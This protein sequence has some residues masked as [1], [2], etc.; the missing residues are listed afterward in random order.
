MAAIILETTGTRISAIASLSIA[1]AFI[2][3]ASPWEIFWIASQQHSKKK[4]IILLQCLIPL[5][6]FLVNLI[7][8]F[9]STILLFDFNI[10]PIA[11]LNTTA[12]IAIGFDA[13]KDVA[14]F[15]G[16]SYWQSRPLAHWRFAETHPTAAG[17]LTPPKG[18]A[19]TGDIYRAF[20]PFA[21]VE[22]RT[23][24]ELLSG[25]TIVTNL[26]TICLA[27]SLGTANLVYKTADTFTAEGL[28]L[29]AQVEPSTGWEGG[30]KVNGNDSLQFSCR[31]NN[32]WDQTDSEAW[33]LSMCSFTELDQADVLHDKSLQN[34]LSGQPYA[35]QPVILLNASD[36]LNG[37]TTTW[38]ETGQNWTSVVI[39][40]W[41]QPSKIVGDDV[42]STALTAKGTEL[43]QASVCFITQNK[44]LL[45]NVT[46]S[47][48][49][50]SAEPR[51]QP[52]W[53]RL[54]AKTGTE[55]IKQL[56]V[57]ISPLDYKA[58]GILD[59][60][61]RSGATSFG[62]DQD[63]EYANLYDFIEA[64]LFD[65]SNT[66]GW[67]FNND[68]FTGS[69]DSS[70]VWS[71]HPEHSLLVQTVL[72]QTGNPA[73]ALQNLF[74]RFYQ[75]IFYDMLPYYTAQQRFELAKAKQVLNPTQWTGL[76]IILSVVAVHLALTLMV[77]WLFA[78]YT[79]LSMLGNAWQAV[80]QSISPD[81]IT[82]VQAVSND[83]MRDKDVQ[84]WTK[85]TVYNERTY[86]LSVSVSNGGSRMR[87][88]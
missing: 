74:F 45:Y 38:N 37:M 54:H 50:I 60:D 1:R 33:P 44:P 65:Y 71:A 76:I 36:V 8:T 80:S 39:P 13:A 86:G 81:T 6:A 73:E 82:V 59:L 14:D 40:K 20:I 43:F 28:Y 62:D 2:A 42:W 23:S 75:M 64:A 9:T 63:D 47:G 15:S 66:G 58:R 25:P 85:S 68:A 26:R 52:K 69:V 5:L 55:F 4:V 88:R 22:D 11:V 3:S 57:G 41:A 16:T 87:E 27:P 12:S 35:F 83:G 51:S 34:P 56:G 10:T 72:Q 17:N 19:D 67:T 79:G 7:A 31:I 70:L 77:I 48:K 24:L 21:N 18:V 84:K 46:M 49:D 29:E 78:T 30:P 32:D 61:I 53:R